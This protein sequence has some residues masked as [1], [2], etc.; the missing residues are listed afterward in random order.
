MNKTSFYIL[1]VLHIIL[2]IGTGAIIIW[3]KTNPFILKRSP[4]ILCTSLIGG[5]I[6][7]IVIL[8]FLT[9]DTQY[10][11]IHH[12]ENYH[13]LLRLRQC[14]TLIGHVFI[15]IPYLLR[16]YRLYFIFHLDK[17]WYED[18]SFFAK[19]IHRTQ[20][21]WLLRILAISFVPLILIC[22]LIFIFPE[23]N[24]FPGSEI[25]SSKTQQDIS[26]S[27]YIIVAFAEQLG[28]VISLYN[29]REVSDDYQM[30]RELMW[31]T[32]MW[33]ITPVFPFFAKTDALYRLPI[34]I[35]N[36]LFLLRSFWIPI[37]ISF[38]NP[39]KVEIVTQEMISSLDLILQSE[40]LLQY[41]EDYLIKI[42]YDT[43]SNL[44]KKITGLSTLHSFMQCEKYLSF[45]CPIDYET[46]KDKMKVFEFASKNL[47]DH[48]II[49]SFKNML[50]NKL[51]NEHF[52]NFLI[53][54]DYKV[55]RRLVTNQ[56]IYF[57][58]ILQTSLGST[59][60][61]RRLSIHILNSLNN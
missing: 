19:N 44:E 60:H 39:I 18:N 29:L 4:L 22:L 8:S 11:I 20:Q 55:L 33:I 13:A 2:F 43:S 37:I 24:Y 32:V 36:D 45:P 9:F 30:T 38:R 41:F 54:H 10:V 52:E 35:R 26:E 7:N 51:K 17:N 27:L 46:L 28:F 48:Q 61:G 49:F 1:T 50:L 6:L 3:R 53:S 34:L 12:K 59:L 58:R 23:G 21:K 40:I 5:L 25:V 16:A 14:A 56:E 47:D 31:V 57:G 42:D 15:V